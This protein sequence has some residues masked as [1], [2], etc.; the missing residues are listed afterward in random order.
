MAE[1]HNSVLLQDTG[2]CEGVAPR[3]LVEGLLFLCG[4]VSLDCLTS[5]SESAL[6]QLWQQMAVSPN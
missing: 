1:I 5:Y 3:T 4:N 6:T 2:Q